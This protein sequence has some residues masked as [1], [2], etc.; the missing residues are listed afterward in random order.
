MPMALKLKP[1]MFFFFNPLMDPSLQT[2]LD[3]LPSDFISKALKTIASRHK[4]D[5][6][7]P[8]TQIFWFF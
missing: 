3:N 6:T 1:S 2:S 5:D 8:K 7:F 4:C